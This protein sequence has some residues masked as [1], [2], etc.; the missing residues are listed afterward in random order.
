MGFYV[1]R[2]LPRIADKA[3]SAPEF[4]R[5]RARAARGLG[6]EV[7]EIG[8]GS[9][10]NLDHYAPAVRRVLAVEP[11]SGARELA[12]GRIAAAPMPVEFVGL[13]GEA[14]P[15]EDESVD[16]ALSTWTLCT[17]SDVGRA[18]DEVRRVLRPGGALHFVEH[19]RAPDAKVVRWQ[20]RLTP[21]QRRAFGGCHL[22]RPIDELIAGAGLAVERLETFYVTGP[23][24]FCFTFE[25]VAVK[26]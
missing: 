19:G 7:L 21:L 14:L 9:G 10:R 8:F 4:S 16:N 3:L 13:E 15:L 1:E 22:N 26:S 25:G 18:L 17:I 2:I 5:L 24:A 23:K 11:A 12:A 20:D 6:G